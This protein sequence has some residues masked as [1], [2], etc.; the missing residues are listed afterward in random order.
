MDAIQFDGTFEATLN[1]CGFM[2]EP[3]WISK[4]FFVYASEAPGPVLDVG[5]AFGVNT[6]PVLR[7]WNEVIAC[8]IDGRHLDELVKRTPMEYRELLTTLKAKFPNNL[9]LP[10]R[11]VGAILLSHVLGF[12][13]GPDLM[14]ASEMCRQWL[15]PGGKLFVIGY[16]PYFNG[17][18]ANITLFEKRLLEGDPWPGDFDVLPERPNLPQRVTHLDPATLRRIFTD[19]IFEI[20]CCGYIGHPQT[21]IPECFRLDGR[22]NVG[23]IATL[24]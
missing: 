17:N 21:P 4:Q 10:N 24:R 13:R 7:R 5:A 1:N 19:E 23:L 9:N 11:S 12:L 22:E 2:F 8:D 6:I 16:S 18:D 20:E 15:I 14:L 3:S